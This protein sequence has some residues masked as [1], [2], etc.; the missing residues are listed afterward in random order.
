MDHTYTLIRSRRKTLALEITR[1]CRILVRA[2][3]R[4]SAAQ[5]DAFVAKHSGWLARNLER[6]KQHLASAPQPPTAEEI[7]ALKAAA[8]AILPGKT[9][10]WSRRMGVTPTGLRITSAR[11]RYG[12]CSSKNS[13]CF[14]CF[15]MRYPEEAIDLVVVHE[16]C[17][18]LEKNHGPRF[19][20]LLE[21][22]LPD[23]KERKKLL[24]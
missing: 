23:Y 20:A 9:A 3:L 6:Q 15:L 13:L 17:H 21:Q 22:Y 4:A 16:L 24:K 18:I 11:K 12:S 8:R 2:P 5:I 19:Y 10:Y 1:D 14:S 7:G